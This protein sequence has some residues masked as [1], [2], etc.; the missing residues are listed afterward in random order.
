MKNNPKPM[1]IRTTIYL[2]I[3]T[4]VEIGISY[5]N[6]PR[7][8]Q[9]GLLVTLSLLKMAFVAYVFMHLYFEERSLRKILFIPIPLMLYFLLGLI[10]EARFEWVIE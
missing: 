4:I 5:W 10:Y 3:I 8:N 9:I 2:A 6:M 7:F 1:Y